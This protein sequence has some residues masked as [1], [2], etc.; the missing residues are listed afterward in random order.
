MRGKPPLKSESANLQI[1]AYL[2]QETLRRKRVL[3]SLLE[4]MQN[5]DIWYNWGFPA[6]LVGWK[7]GRMAK[8]RFP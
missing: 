3:K 8:L 2:S 5:H 7:D 4:L 1:F 6:C